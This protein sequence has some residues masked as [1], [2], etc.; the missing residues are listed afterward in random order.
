MQ[1]KISR[2]KLKFFKKSLFQSITFKMMNYICV[3]K[4]KELFTYILILD[5]S[6]KKNRDNKI[7]TLV[8]V[9]LVVMYK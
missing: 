5:L 9:E 1:S 2:I 3:K 7:L 8:K 6:W 4:K